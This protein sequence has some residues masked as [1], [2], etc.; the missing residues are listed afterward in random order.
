MRNILLPIVL[1]ACTG[2]YA[3]SPC[4]VNH[5][6]SVQVQT[7][8]DCATDDSQPY[9]YNEVTLTATIDSAL[10][11]SY[12]WSFRN[13]MN[14]NVWQALRPEWSFNANYTWLPNPVTGDTGQ[15]RLVFTENGSGCTDTA[16]GYL[17]LAPGPNMAVLYDSITCAGI[18]YRIV[19]L[20]NPTGAGMTLFDLDGNQISD[21]GLYSGVGCISVGR[22]LD[23]AVQNACGYFVFT[24]E[25]C[26]WDFLDLNPYLEYTQATFCRGA[27]AP[28]NAKRYFFDFDPP[29][30]WTLQWA[31][32]GSILPG[33]SGN[34][35]QPTSSGSY[36]CI[37]T[38]ALGCTAS[39]LPVQVNIL[40][41]PATTLSQTGTNVR[42]H[43]SSLPL[44]ASSSL[45]STYQ[46]FRNGQALGTSGN[47]INISAPGRYKV[48]ATATNGCTRFSPITTYTDYS[49]KVVSASGSTLCPGDS[50][51]LTAQSATG[52]T[53]IQWLRNNVLITGA[54]Q[55]QYYARQ[56][57]WHKVIA[58]STSGC[59]DTSAGFNVTLSANCRWG[60]ASTELQVDLYPNPAIDRIMLA[61]SGPT[62][63]H[64]ELFTATGAK[65]WEG[66]WHTELDL[67]HW[68]SGLYLLRI[69]AGESSL[70]RRFEITR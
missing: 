22:F 53:A 69:S 20:N 18:Y 60:M 33:V 19:D 61:S 10:N 31:K 59:I 34:Y 26:N 7:M 52:T 58:T 70:L 42:C 39:T 3:Q 23:I 43:T 64:M 66:G 67:G 13:A 5:V 55:P 65:V 30:T 6:S 17:S 40:P 35:F 36:T 44:S 11:G 63:D 12:T 2:S 51:L 32:N 41:L 49:V 8:S 29:S 28:L 48:L 24:H 50:L 38:N 62:P 25:F 37:V 45:P 21:V 27:S 56:A 47:S 16:Y 54:N 46:W 68:P 1:F 15:Y 4:T 57:G 9:F 14:G